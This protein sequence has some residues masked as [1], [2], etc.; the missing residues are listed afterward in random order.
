MHKLGT[1]IYYI[2]DMINIHIIGAALAASEA[3]EGFLCSGK[4]IKNF[5]FL[6]C[7]FPPHAL[8]KI[9]TVHC[10]LNKG[11]ACYFIYHV[12]FFSLYSKDY[13]VIILFFIIDLLYCICE[14]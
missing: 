10:F 6:F 8:L 3:C 1:D 5:C 7:F 11:M 12:F 13:Y 4:K 14:L 9:N 2:I